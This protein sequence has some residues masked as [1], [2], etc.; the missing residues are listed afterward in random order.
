MSRKS[1]RPNPPPDSDERYR[2]NWNS[3]VMISPHNPAR[4]Y[5]GGN[6][7]FISDDRGDTWRS[8]EDLTRQIDRDELEIMGVVNTRIRLSRNDG[9]S[10]YGNITTISESP[11]TTGVIWV[12]TDDGNLQLSRDGGQTWSNVI[13]RLD[14]V[15]PRT[16]VTRIEASRYAEGRAY[17]TF[18]GHR[19]NDFTPY[20]FVTEDFGR[21]WRRISGGIPEGSCANCIREHHRNPNLLFLGTERGAYWSFDRGETWN[22]FEGDLPRVP[23]DDIYIHPVKNDLIFGTHARGAYIMDDIASL[24][25]MSAAVL[26]S[27]FTLFPVRYTHRFSRFSHLQD[28]GE[29]LFNAPNPPYGAIINYFLSE[30]MGAEGGVE[31]RI[32]DASGNFVRSMNGTGRRGVNRVLWDLQHSIEGAEPEPGQQMRFRGGPQAPEAVPGTYTVTVTAAGITQSQT[33]EVRLDPRLEGKVSIPDMIA[34]RDVQI[35]L[36][37][38]MVELN[39]PSR[40]LNDLDTQVR[41]LN[42]FLRTKRGVPESARQ[43]LDDFSQEIRTMNTELFAGGGF[44]GGGDSLMGRLSMLSRELSGLTGPVPADINARLDAFVPEIEAAAARVDEFITLRVPELNRA[45]SSAGIPF[46]QPEGAAPPPGAM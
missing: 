42:E 7:L 30:E 41:E 43:A 45:L 2:F 10:T 40:R 1:I 38:L 27:P 22:M 23:V 39:A 35:R 31:I 26:S 29:F 20:V 33:V 36:A 19:N 4:I 37:G 3:P 32:T 9:I 8:T 13:E 21:R 44:R 6:K 25:G 15:S 17:V 11:H 12:G 24:E 16:Y 34:L 46:I 18:D 5:F 28:Q 14:G